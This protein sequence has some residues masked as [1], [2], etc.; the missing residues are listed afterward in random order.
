[1]YVGMLADKAGVQITHHPGFLVFGP[2]SFAECVL[3]KDILLWH[4]VVGH[5]LFKIQEQMLERE[6]N[7]TLIL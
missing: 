6:K 7:E 1:M 4:G 5:C 2:K 3:P